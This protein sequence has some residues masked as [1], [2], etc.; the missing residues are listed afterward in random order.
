[1][2]CCHASPAP[3][4]AGTQLPPPA[5]LELPKA[6]LDAKA[7]NANQVVLA[8]WSPID[9]KHAH[10]HSHSHSHAHPPTPAMPDKHT[11]THTPPHVNIAG[12]G[13]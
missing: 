8:C 3:A 2:S 9:A 11:H 7:A 12:V 13:G 10:A 1:M 5:N 4:S 6:K